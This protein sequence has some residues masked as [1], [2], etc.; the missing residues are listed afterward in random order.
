MC[1]VY[2]ILPYND[3]LYQDSQCTYNVAL[4]RVRTTIAAVENS[5]CIKNMY[6]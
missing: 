1:I 5:E 2:K 3:S 6:L 4:G